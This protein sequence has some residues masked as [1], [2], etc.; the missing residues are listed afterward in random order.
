MQ[1]RMQLGKL[2]E[3]ADKQCAG[4][5]AQQREQAG[6]QVKVAQIAPVQIAVGQPVDHEPL[7]RA[8]RVAQYGIHAQRQ[9]GHDQTGGKNRPQRQAQA[10][11]RSGVVGS[12]IHL[13]DGRL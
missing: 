4:A 2:E 10:G 1:P 6:G 3:I 7:H 9:H 13:D 8:N 5:Q 12:P 11:L